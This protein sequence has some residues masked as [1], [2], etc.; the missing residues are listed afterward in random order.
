MLERI[1]GL[2]YSKHLLVDEQ[3]AMFLHVL[4]HCIKN[5]VIQFEFGRSGETISK[6]I[7]LVLNTMMQLEGELFKTLE[8][9]SSD[10]IDE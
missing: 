6:Y 5:R 2:K 8:P 1:G 4:A 3:G 7:N 10:S 9:I